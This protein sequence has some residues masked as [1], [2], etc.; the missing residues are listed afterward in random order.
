MSATGVTG[1]LTSVSV[2][3]EFKVLTMVI[4]DISLIVLKAR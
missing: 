4:A 1:A 2:N 3:G